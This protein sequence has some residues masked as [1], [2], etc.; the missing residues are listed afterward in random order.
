MPMTYDLNLREYWRTIR[1]R[2]VIVIFTI[3]MMTLFSFI[4]SIL[5]RPTPIYKTSASVK[6]E[7]SEYRHG[8]LPPVR[9]LHP[10]RTT[11]KPRWP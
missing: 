8:S 5:G 3:V 6:V 4:F 9:F 11:W 7:K 2:K 10:T 1:K